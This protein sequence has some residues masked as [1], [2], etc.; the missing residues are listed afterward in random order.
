MNYKVYDLSITNGQLQATKKQEEVLKRV[1]SV[2]VYHSSI[3][4]KM[5]VGQT[6]DFINR[7]KQHFNGSE[8]RFVVSNYDE[9]LVLVPKGA[10]LSMILDIESKLITYLKTDIENS[11]AEKVNFAEHSIENANSGVTVNSYKNRIDTDGKIIVPFWKDELFKRGW[12]DNDSIDILKENALVTY[13]P[14][15]MLTQQQSDI[16][17]EILHNIN[18]NFV[19]N[20]DAGT[21]KTVL[22][23][24]LV[25]ALLENDR[26]ISVAVVVQPN[27]E[28]TAKN[29][30]K[31]YGIAEDNLL[32]TT[33][34]KLITDYEK[35]HKKFDVIIV[36]EAHKTSRRFGKQHPS[37]NSV[38]KGEFENK[39]N[40]LEILENIG[41]QKIFFY[42]VLQAIRPANIE[43]ASFFNLTSEYKHFYLKTQ[44]RINIGDNEN[45]SSDDYVNGIKFLLYKDTGL[46]KY[47]SFNKDFDRGVFHG[48]SQDDYFGIVGNKPLHELFD[49]IDE[50]MIENPNH[51]DRVLRGLVEPWKQKDGKDPKKMHWF[52]DEIQRRWNSTQVNW[53]NSKEED[54][55]AQIGS[56]FAVQGIDLN[57]VGVLMGEDLSITSEGKLKADSDHFYNVNGTFKKEE[58]KEVEKQDEFTLF[59][60]NIYY[61]LLTRGVDGVRIGF[62]H[63]EKLRQYVMDTL[64][65]K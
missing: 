47:T 22:L 7:N 28:Q 63:N 59:V 31:I 11:K 19:V 33:S 20:G 18:Q 5:Y 6:S 43:R 1:N 25:A 61:V 64:D 4:G 65:I 46:L 44:L 14:Y 2:Y 51:I 16:V 41:D 56:V 62:W 57:C 13:S 37:F 9:V 3:T 34:T 38:Y 23:T 52:E 58:M 53:I 15:K 32:I 55:D 60:L 29:I 12:V 17:N 50:D 42:D 45:Y 49:W 21:G 35:N 48:A 39:K 27:W 10:D 24:H 40:H 36:D 30:F 54:A 8:K 26:D